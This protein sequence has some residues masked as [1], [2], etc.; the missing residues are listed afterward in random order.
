MTRIAGLLQGTILR[1]SRARALAAIGAVLIVLSPL[2]AQQS[3][4]APAQ[5]PARVLEGHVING[6]TNRPVAKAQV[7]YVLMA[8]GMEPAATQMTDSEGKFRFENMPPTNGPALLRVDYQGATY[9]HPVLP[10]QA[11]QE[12]FDIPVYDAG[13]D[14]GMISV[15]EHAIFVHPS[16]KTLLVLEQVIVGNN[17][18]PPKTYVN[19]E[20]TFPYTLAG[21]PAQPPQVTVEG[22]GGM[23][24]G[25]TPIQKAAPNSFAIA[26][27]IR[28]GETQIRVEYTLDYHAPFEFSKVLDLPPERVHIVTPGTGVQ[29]TGDGLTPV[30][31]DPSTGFAGYQATPKGDLVRVEISGDVPAKAP[32]GDSQ[33][34]GAE[35][36][37]AALVPIADPVS[38]RRWY[39]VSAAGLV[40]LAGLVY[41]LRHD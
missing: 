31:T 40:M 10:G 34:E 25:Q 37:S 22:P 3:T 26:Y 24:I 41:H 1:L 14:R 38:S 39:I 16:G 13:H 18:K 27:P 30:G 2:H 20:G 21:T 12:P 5:A 11:S 6:T 36:E 33:N 8:Q 29:V 28:P 23:P 17:S 4:E 15:R 32:V 35:G 19:A 9:S 7:R